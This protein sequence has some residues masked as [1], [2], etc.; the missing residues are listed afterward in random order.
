M[1]FSDV[2]GLPAQTRVRSDGL[3]EIRI[4]GEK[5]G[6]DLAAIVEAVEELALVRLEWENDGQQIPAIADQT[7]RPL[8]QVLVRRRYTAAEHRQKLPVD[9]ARIRSD[10]IDRCSSPVPP[11][12]PTVDNEADPQA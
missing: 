12:D 3:L 8:H 9:L 4:P 6:R 2:E 7:I 5:L 11:V 1:E 10:V